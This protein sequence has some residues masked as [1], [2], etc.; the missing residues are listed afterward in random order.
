MKTENTPAN[1]LEVTDLKTHFYVDDGVLR[2]V[3]GVSF[4]VRRG[5]VLALVGESAC[6]KTVTA[7]SILRLIDRP[8]RI[9]GGRVLLH[10]D[11][12]RIDV[13]ALDEKSDELFEVRGGLIS[14]IFQEPMTALSPVHTIANQIVEAIRLHRGAGKSQARKMAADMLTRV[15]IPGA[16]GRL[17]SYPHE[18]SGGMRQRV[19][20]AMALATGPQLLIAD[21]PTTALDVT[22]QAQVLRLIKSLQDDFGT[23][24]MFITHN[25]GVVAQIA[26]DVAVMYLG[27]IVERGRVIDVMKR[28]RHPYT[29]CLLKSL[30]G[31]TE[32][33]RRLQSIA[34]SVPALAEVPPGCPFHPRCPHCQPGRCD[35]GAPPPLRELTGGQMAACLRAEEIQ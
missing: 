24:V 34:G 33:R 1:V 22:I 4:N 20:I 25:L 8:G 19:M 30:P 12:R 7:Y 6:G 26:D 11:G 29:Q 35:V 17:G 14:M 15:G 32:S 3:D 21:E 13:T 10:A 23:S 27:R 28:P 16:E 31:L 5:K 9:V 2:A 18:M